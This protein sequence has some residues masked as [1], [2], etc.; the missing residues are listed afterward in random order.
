MTEKRQDAVLIW[1]DIALTAIRTA[2]TPP[3]PAARH[4]AMLHIAIADTVNTIYQTHRPYQIALRATE[5]ID[6]DVAAAA[7]A[8]RILTDFYPRQARTFDRALN[9]D[10]AAAAAALRVRAG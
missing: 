1:N 5:P 10:T 2:K 7:A 9:D 3:P 8:A 4:L 6:P